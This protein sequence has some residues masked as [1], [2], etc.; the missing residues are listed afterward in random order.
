MAA[1]PDA[2]AVSQ[3]VTLVRRQWGEG[4]QAARGIASV[5]P[6]PPLPPPPP[7]PEPPACSRRAAA[8]P[9]TLRCS[10]R[11]SHPQSHVIKTCR[12]GSREEVTLTSGECTEA[13][14]S[15]VG[16]ACKAAVDQ[17][18]CSK[19][20]FAMLMIL[21]DECLVNGP[22]IVAA[23]DAAAGASANKVLDACGAS[24]LSLAPAPA[25]GK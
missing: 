5:L 17:D 9:P 7:R 3:V 4:R 21:P 12:L 10:C 16:G 22:G 6:V 15:F 23:K 1:R 19:D 20:C 25:P 11:P 24:G 2:K 8:L 18:V 13:W 14:A